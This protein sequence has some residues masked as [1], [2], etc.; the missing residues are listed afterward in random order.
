M[1]APAGGGLTMTGEVPGVSLAAV[2]LDERISRS[3]GRS[4]MFPI[5]MP[6]SGGP[7]SVTSV[8]GFAVLAGFVGGASTTG[9]LMAQ[10]AK[11]QQAATKTMKP[12]WRMLM[13]GILRV[14]GEEGGAKSRRRE[15][16]PFCS[17]VQVRIRSHLRLDQ[18]SS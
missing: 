14:A 10:P 4:I 6:P 7:G 15:A 8:G 5:R 3:L 18:K 16:C 13:E 17:P 1:E 12:E 9:D 2:G 11:A